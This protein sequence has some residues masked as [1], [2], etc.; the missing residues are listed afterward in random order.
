VPGFRQ[1]LQVLRRGAL[2]L[3][4]A[5]AAACAGPDAARHE[6]PGTEPTPIAV[7]SGARPVGSGAR[8]VALTP[9]PRRKRAPGIERDD[10]DRVLDA[11]PGAFLQKVPLAPVFGPGRRF[12]G[13]RIVSLWRNNPRVLRYG[14]R[15][16]D[17]VRSVNGH[18]IDTPDQ[19]LGVFKLLRN[20]ARI[21]VAVTRAGRPMRFGWPVYDPAPPRRPQGT[22]GARAA[23]AP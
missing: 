16:G 2:G 11:G 14:V 23:A 4:V 12:R 18:P 6:G 7:G 8:S 17:I 9:K 13:F 15:P 20:A 1:V 21:D 5:L 19:L 10:L 3:T 22:R